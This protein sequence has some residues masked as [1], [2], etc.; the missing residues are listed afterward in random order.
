M[1][2]R[3][4]G[5]HPEKVGSDIHDLVRLTAG[6]GAVVVAT[7]V[8]ALGVELARWVAD[9]V[10]HSFA[11]PDLRYTLIR[12]RRFDRSAGAGRDRGPPGDRPAGHRSGRV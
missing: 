1:V 4:H 11:G 8:A 3:P 9:H 5:N 2:R 10:E 6:I 7:E 12:F